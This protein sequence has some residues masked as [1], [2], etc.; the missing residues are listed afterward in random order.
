MASAADFAP[1]PGGV[2]ID[3]GVLYKNNTTTPQRIGVIEGDAVFTVERGFRWVPYNN[4]VSTRTKNLGRKQAIDATL[5]I[6]TI[7]MTAQTLA[8]VF[9]G[10][11]LSDEGTYYKITES[12]EI[13]AADYWTD[14]TL[15]GTTVNDKYVKIVLFNAFC[16]SN[17]EQ[18]F[19]KDEE[20]ITEL[21]IYA[22]VDPDYPSTIPYEYDIEK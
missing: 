16:E 17:T 13:T 18:T 12:H 14:A 10:M 22:T 20:V 1:S 2:W 15:L 8:E 9:A 3:K 19:K 5:K 6:P 7:E 21:N 11:T 4:M